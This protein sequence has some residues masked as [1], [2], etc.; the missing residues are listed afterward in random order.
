MKKSQKKK[1]IVWQQW[2]G[3]I[4]LLL[5]GAVC[6]FLMMNYLYSAEVANRSPIEKIGALL[7]LFVIMYLAF[8]IQMIIHEAGHLVFGL[9]SGYKFSS[10]RI[11]NFMW[12]K[13]NNKIKL[14]RFTLAGT[15][16]QCLMVPPDLVDG[17]IPVVLYN[18]GGS[19]MNMVA[20]LVFLCFYFVTV[21]LSFLSTVML[22]LSVIG[23]I[24]AIMNGVPMRMGMVN[25][26]GYNVFAL[27]RNR[28]A[29]RSFWIQMKI[30]EQITK[31]IRLKDMPDEWFFIPSDD[32]M[33]NSMVAVMGVTACNR[34]MDIQNFEEANKAISRLLEIES[35]IVDIHRNLMVCDRIFC[36]LISGNVAKVAELYTK[37][38]KKFMKLMK[39]F[40]TVLRTEYTYALLSECDALK[41]EAIKAE[42][43]KCVKKYPH[44]NEVAAERELMCIADDNYNKREKR[45]K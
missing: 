42:Y 23:F 20:A 16:G 3:I 26:D 4:F 41:A 5:I 40:P 10:F 14:R 25:N 32:E 22:M 9:A 1:K 36:E 30:N 15:G 18:L 28:D 37:E 6:G 29:L 7:V 19:I 21:S 38:L 17:K 2:I 8:F 24:I 39:K 12:V 33:T 43:E 44:P 27:I 13:E 45:L 11:I 34:L 31:G 35:G